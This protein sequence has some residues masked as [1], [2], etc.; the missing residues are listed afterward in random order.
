M[1]PVLLYAETHYRFRFF[2]SY[3]KKGEPEVIADVPH[4]LEPGAGIPLLLIVKDAD[5]YPCTLGPV[6][7]SISQR[8]NIVQEQELLSP[9]L[10]IK[11]P[12]WWY[13]Y[14]L[15]RPDLHGWIDIQVRMTITGNGSSRTYVSDNH[16][17]S[18]HAPLRV[19][20]SDEHLP[21]E[22][23]LFLGDAHTHSDRTSDMVEF[24]VPPRAAVRLSQSLG[25]S[26][27]CVADHSYDLDDSADDYTRNDPAL[28]KWTSLVD[29]IKQWNSERHEFVIVQ[30]EEVSCRNSHDRNV[31]LLLFGDERFF[32]GTGDGAERWLRTRCE[33][34][35][36][37][38]LAQKHKHAVAFAAHPGE[39]VSFLQRV[40]LGRGTW[41]EDDTTNGSL[42][43]LQFANGM[44]GF[45]F[46]E[47]YRLWI[48]AL[49]AGRHLFCIAGN[50]AHGN[51]NRFRQIGVPFF[52][53]R[54]NENQL[55]GKMRTGVFIRGPFDQPAILESLAKGRSIAT[56]GPVANIVV[57]GRQ[58]LTSLGS[59]F[60]GSEFEIMLSTSSSKE[61][62]EIEEIRLFLGIIGEESERTLF[63]E[64]STNHFKYQRSTP[65]H[66]SSPCYVRA[67]THTSALTSCDQSPHFCLTNPIWFTP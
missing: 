56:D 4:R 5:Q 49:L 63:Y 37:D 47:G 62:G 42:A 11:Q 26:F 35:I 7:V 9:P 38:V 28:P 8:G 36:E 51:F 6:V 2:F 21:R 1:L 22:Q 46:E 40:L 52:R 61:F 13:V 67:E 32:H 60:V 25:L 45:G 64:R 15:P 34:N 16:R 24:G 20:L 48:R 23:G 10:S 19:F 3:L 31:H 30:G 18:S 66:V 65:I 17:T 39:E 50:D 57:Q 14:D 12:L 44:R 53:I 54:E 55:F 41:S 33:Y 59:T 27:F 43:G 29:E 58:T